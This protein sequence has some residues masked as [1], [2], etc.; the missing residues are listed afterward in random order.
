MAE[1]QKSFKYLIETADGRKFHVEFDKEPT[2]ESIN[3]ALSEL[4]NPGQITQGPPKWVEPVRTG[5]D[6]GSLIVGGKFGGPV[7]AGLLY[8]GQ[9]QASDRILELLG[10]N[11]PQT[12]I[13]AATTA[14][15]DVLAGMA[16]E[17]GGRILPEVISGVGKMVS[18]PWGAYTGSGSR[19]IQ[20]AYKGG[21]GFVEYMRKQGSLPELV[22]EAKTGLG[23]LKEIRAS[24]YLPKL[25]KIS[26]FKGDMNLK[27]L[28]QDLEN[29]M[30]KFNITEIPKSRGGGFDYTNSIL[31]NDKGAQAQFEEIYEMIRKRKMGEATIK[32]SDVD[33]LKRNLADYYSP[34]DKIRALTTKLENTTHDILSS[35]FREYKEMTAQYR[36]DSIVINEVLKDFSIGERSSYEQGIRKLTNAM[37]ESNEFRQTLLDLVKERTGVDLLPKLAGFQMA[38]IIPTSLVGRM[39][40]MYEVF[41]LMQQADP[42]L[43][44]ALVSSS[45]RIAGEFLNVLGKV[46]PTAL[47]GSKYI[48]QTVQSYMQEKKESPINWIDELNKSKK[49]EKPKVIRE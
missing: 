45:P 35:K 18:Y 48:P 10:I 12:P 36:K 15:K 19:S 6:L 34:N 49:E 37:K 25:E 2:N 7:G 28:Y 9:R 22:S 1:E 16:T 44:M 26:R 32:A 31:E 14:G 38:S 30:K 5:L 24:E 21:E 20:E 8:G 4:S 43:V 13:E 3:R 40:G 29:Q 17:A 33:I 27:P 46:G 11:K 39:G 41:Q 47:K 23:V 42:R